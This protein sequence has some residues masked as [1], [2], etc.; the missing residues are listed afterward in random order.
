MTKNM[1]LYQAVLVASTILGKPIDDDSLKKLA[2]IINA[3][4]GLPPQ[5]RANLAHLLR[6]LQPF[7]LFTT[8]DSCLVPHGTA[9]IVGFE[10]VSMDHAIFAKANPSLWESLQKKP[11]SLLIVFE[12][13]QA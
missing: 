13:T 10:G 6:A 12:D 5:E 9:V 8:E 3:N 2:E 11:I 4:Y 7:K 1:C